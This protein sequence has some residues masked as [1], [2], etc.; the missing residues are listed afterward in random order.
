MGISS[1]A[2]RVSSQ[3]AASKRQAND[4]IEAYSKSST[5]GLQAASHSPVVSTAA[6][7]GILAGFQS[8]HHAAI[9]QAALP[10]DQSVQAK[11]PAF[12]P[13]IPCIAR[14]HLAFQSTQAAAWLTS[15]HLF[16]VELYSRSVDALGSIPDGVRGAMS[17]GD[18]DG[19][20]TR[21]PICRHPV[22]WGKYGMRAI[23]L[24]AQCML[25]VI[26]SCS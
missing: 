1:S 15:Q 3:K 7:Q 8:L 12:M 23:R 16:D 25:N 6:G 17:S 20:L 14:P 24:T 5:I 9:C 11:S 4:R 26:T 18:V 13:L 10:N 21:P 19:V 2:C 22:D